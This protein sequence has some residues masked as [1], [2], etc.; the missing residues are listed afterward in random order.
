[1]NKKKKIPCFS[2]CFNWIEKGNKPTRIIDSDICKKNIENYHLIVILLCKIMKITEEDYEINKKKFLW[3][4]KKNHI[5][6][7]CQ[8]FIWN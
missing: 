8:N 4:E 3:F 1:M 7:I 5:R 6:K 2:I